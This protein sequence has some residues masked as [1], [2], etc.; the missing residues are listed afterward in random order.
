MGTPG[1]PFYDAHRPSGSLVPGLCLSESALLL[2]LSLGVPA[3]A[4]HPRGQAP[5]ISE[6]RLSPV[7]SWGAQILLL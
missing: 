5:G 3:V 2:V 7:P 1:P 6:D 4:G